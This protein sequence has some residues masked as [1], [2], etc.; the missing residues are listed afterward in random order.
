VKAGEPARG[1]R[2]PWLALTAG[3]LSWLLSSAP[4]DVQQR[5]ALT[6]AAWWGQPWRLWT[7]HLVH[8]G[9]AHLRGDLI[10][11][12]V[13]AALLEQ[14]DRRA[15]ARI[16]FLATPVL[17]LALLAAHPRLNEYRGLSAID[18]SLV[19]ALIGQRGFANARFR[20]F[21]PACLAGFALKCVYEMTQ[22]RALFAPDL[23]GGAKLLPM[24]HV[25]GAM[26]GAVL[27]AWAHHV[28]CRARFSYGT[29]P[30]TSLGLDEL[31]RPRRSR[32]ARL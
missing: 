4:A 3:A 19:V 8:F 30:D 21:G 13:W 29:A 32:A 12:V 9:A 14:R 10:A 11:F 18:C 24:A 31:G 28:G 20:W 26:L 1:R 27:Q 25:L 5:C 22:G 6:P 15:L 2:A 16:L 7:G 17:S 23:G